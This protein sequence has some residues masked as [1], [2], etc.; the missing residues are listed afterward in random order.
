MDKKFILALDQGTTGSR[1]FLFDK[2]GRIVA[3]AYKE[4]KQY[5]P[6]PGWVEHDAEEIWK[7]CTDVIRGA[8]RKGRVSANQMAAIGITNQ[9]ETT[10][11]WDRKTSKP[12]ARAIVWQC[13]RTADICRDL[14]KHSST[15]RK[16]T[17]LVLDPYFSGTKIKNWLKY[18]SLHLEAQPDACINCGKCSKNCP[19]GLQVNE[20][21]QKDNM[22]SVDCINC[23]E[24]VSNCPKDAISFAWRWKKPKK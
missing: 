17:G 9:R 13:R 12:V 8:L 19:M 20:M 22:C 16:K 11:L 2:Q 18:P 10:V 3:S 6:K 21:V 7:S 4:F 14:I 15:F 1:A 23:G 5:F 24:C